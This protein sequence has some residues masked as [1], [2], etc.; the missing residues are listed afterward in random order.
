MIFVDRED[1][2]NKLAELLREY[3][4]NPK[5]FLILAIPRGGVP[6]AYRVSKEL[7]IPLKVIVVRKLGI[8]WNKEAAFGSIDPSGK[9]YVDEETVRYLGLSEDL[10]RGVAEEEYEELKRRERTF[11]PEGYPDMR[12]K[13]V[14]IIDDGVATGYTA[15]A[16]GSFARDMGA[17]EVWLAVPVCPARMDRRVKETF[18]RILCLHRDESPAFAVGMFYQDFHQLSD[19][20]VIGM[21]SDIPEN[22]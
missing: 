3:V 19:E 1:A 14:I 8:P 10:I 17:G 7:G 5:D 2:G 18:D 22:G 11:L 21:L 20:E 12:G 4:K 15:V 6:V 13:K 9:V 16:A